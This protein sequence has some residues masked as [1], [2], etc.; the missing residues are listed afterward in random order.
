MNRPRLQTD[1]QMGRNGPKLSCY[2]PT[3]LMVSVVIMVMLRILQPSVL[4]SKEFSSLAMSLD[5]KPLSPAAFQQ[6]MNQWIWGTRKVPYTVDSA[7]N[8]NSD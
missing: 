4:R 1:Q 7:V 3:K 2:S 5:R 8:N 6:A